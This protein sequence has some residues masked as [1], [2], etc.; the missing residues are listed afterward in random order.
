MS[1][2]DI[3][4][5]NVL[6]VEGVDNWKVVALFVVSGHSKCHGPNVFSMRIDMVNNQNVMA[7]I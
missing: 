7:L 3:Q 2:P 4:G 6:I 1:D 5:C